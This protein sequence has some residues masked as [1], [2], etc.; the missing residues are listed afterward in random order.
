[1]IVP[2]GILAA[3]VLLLQM[4]AGAHQSVQ[5][6]GEAAAR[7]DSLAHCWDLERNARRVIPRLYWDGKTDSLRLVVAGVR[8]KCPQAS[9]DNLVV[10]LSIDDGTYDE[11]LCDSE[12]IA[13]I[14]WGFSRYGAVRYPSYNEHLLSQIPAVREW[15]EF[16]AQYID[17]LKTRVDS[18]S[19]AFVQL[20][21]YVDNVRYILRRLARSELPGTCLQ[22]TYTS[23]IE[24]LLQTR[25]RRR[26]HVY[27]R[28]G[29]WIPVGGNKVLGNKLEVGGQF[30]V[31][32]NRW[33]CGLDFAA[34]FLGESEPYRVRAGGEIRQ[35]KEFLG[36][37]VGCSTAYEVI[38]A[39][40]W[41]ADV[42]ATVGFDGIRAV[43]RTGRNE[44]EWI[45]SPALGL[46]FTHRVCFDR[47]CTRYLGLQWRCT[48]VDYVTHG[49]SDL[50]GNAL[51]L[52]L[53]WG[54]MSS[55]ADRHLQRLQYF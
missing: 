23:S 33:E 14:W 7:S 2:V 13:E 39:R 19:T 11:C 22:D 16:T 51:S 29:I 20:Q 9:F 48:I 6:H 47:G 50:S 37:F 41:S 8:E 10:L 52:S 43:S 45:N 35:T 15:S 1:M 28:T 38:R 31:R 49:G 27:G 46:G 18:N 3:G 42:F 24:A 12:M 34:R 36:L 25:Y 55:G 21:Y 40:R 32:D 53:V 44:A 17:D 26:V 54:A 4:Q 30:A 5:Q